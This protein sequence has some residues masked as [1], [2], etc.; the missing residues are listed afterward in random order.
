[1]WEKRSEKGEG[2]AVSG[3]PNT[4]P[5]PP[6]RIREPVFWAFLLVGEAGWVAGLV[7]LVVGFV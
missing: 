5:R 7:Y 3:F 4:T 6:E 1:M 2:V